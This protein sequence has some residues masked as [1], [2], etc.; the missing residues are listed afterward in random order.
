MSLWRAELG[1][2]LD[3]PAPV[4]PSDRANPQR[5]ENNQTLLASEP[6]A[7]QCLV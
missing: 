5:E 6:A 7:I 3:M 4:D 2:V 1:A